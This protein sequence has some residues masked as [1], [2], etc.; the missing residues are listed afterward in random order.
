M[1]GRR[2][3][4]LFGYERSEEIGPRLFSRIAAR[5]HRDARY[6]PLADG[7]YRPLV[8]RLRVPWEIS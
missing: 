6:A 5:L 3:V 7:T 8:V 2:H 1:L 4:R